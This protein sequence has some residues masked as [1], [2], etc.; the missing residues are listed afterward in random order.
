MACMHEQF[1]FETHSSRADDSCDANQVDEMS[2]ASFVCQLKILF[3]QTPIFLNLLLS[4]RNLPTGDEVID[5]RVIGLK[6]MSVKLI[7][8]SSLSTTTKNQF[9][10]NI[11]RSGIYIHY[12]HKLVNL[13]A[14]HGN[15][16][17]AGLALRLHAD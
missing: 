3:D 2:R 16:V 8:S 10:R 17:E 13:D 12:V 14:A 11:G 15:F 7:K 5:D 9:I 4:I 1:N 6:L